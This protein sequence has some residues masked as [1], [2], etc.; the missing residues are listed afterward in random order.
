M[1]H[2]ILN[3]LLAAQILAA[4]VCLGGEREFNGA[5]VSEIVSKD[6]SPEETTAL[7]QALGLRVGRALD[8]DRLDAAIKEA[9]ASGKWV[10]VWVDAE[11]LGRKAKIT[12]RGMKLRTVR[13]LS[14]EGIQEDVLEQVRR[15]I[16]T[17]Q[18]QTADVE[19]FAH[20]RQ[21]LKE[22]YEDRGY[23][24]AQVQFAVK[25]I[26]EDEADVEIRVLPGEPTH[27]SRIQFRGVP[28]SEQSTL[29]DLISLQRG[30]TFSAITLNEGVEK[31]NAYFRANQYPTSRVQDTNLNFIN[32]TKDVEI[33]I[34][35]RMGERFQIRFVGNDV[36][37]DVQL[38]ALLTE[39]VLAQT[40]PTLRITQLIEEKYRTVGYPDCTVA[41]RR[42]LVENGKLNLMEMVVEEGPRTVI[43]DVRFST[44]DRISGVDLDS[45][46]Y[47]VAVGVLQRRL[48]WADGVA[49]T[50][51]AMQNRL[52]TMGYLNAR[53]SDPKT[54]FSEDRRSVILFIDADVGFQTFLAGVDFEGVRSF[55]PEE[56]ASQFS[57]RV[58]KPL[59]REQVPETAN[60]ILKYY[61]DNGFPDARLTQPLD[62]AVVI[63]T[64]QQSARVKFYIDEGQPYR[65]GNVRVEGLRKTKSKVVLRE[66]E[67]VSGDTYSARKIRSSEEKVSLLGLFSKVEIVEV[68]VPGQTGT[69]DL[70]ILVVETK[71]GV[72][73]MGIGT[74]Y[75]EPR[76][77]IRPFMGVTY[78][79]VSGLNQ[80]ASV[81]ADLGVPISRVA[82][83]LTVP[84]LEYSTILAYRYPYA[85]GLPVTFASQLGLDRVEVQPTT[86]T[87]LT[88]ARFEGRLEKKFSPKLTGI[89]RLLRVERT[90][91]Q[92]GDDASTK[93][94]ESIGSMGPGIILDLRDDIFNPRWGSFH[95][96]DI[97]LATSWL[98][99]QQDISFIMAL[100]RNS[101]YFPLSRDIQ[102]AVYA[103]FGLAH[104]FFGDPIAR[105]RLVNELSLGGQ[106]S[107]RGI[108]P[109]ALSPGES[110]REMAYYNGRLE[111]TY[112]LIEDFGVAAFIDTGQI[113]PDFRASQRSDGVGIGLRY[114]TP[115]GPVVVD[116]AK[117]I[118]HLGGEFRFYFTVG[119]I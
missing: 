105:A 78:R 47:E 55:S 54:T 46:F 39:D 92:D 22:G 34:N 96:L 7:V 29:A 37:S 93:K 81:R 43:E 15:K 38:R 48:Y 76:L 73:E 65:I 31:V 11:Q 90:T 14:F 26:D 13:K 66:M 32:G 89:Y 9:G 16:R 60:K 17:D 107:I 117:G 10:R 97:E 80:T 5:V 103:G 44:G 85:L 3:L 6:L 100:W 67:L 84:F 112:T 25:N 68:R 18:E 110:S 30:D 19:S 114:K 27:I 119:T 12:V 56:L 64:D 88:R 42:S 61:A 87:L 21:A 95:S 50:L 86:Q 62:H 45:L 2:L 52:L 51:T 40:D 8:L 72:G 1:K 99:S 102:V 101:F 113:F 53:V 109:R 83:N 77:R 24:S 116:F 115:V 28:E 20:L 104:S 98:F 69:V 58:G 70:R 71:P 91:T 82:G 33:L 108:I 49:E 63:S 75:E 74:L 41:V 59:N 4:G 118:N 111:V 106:G 35:V 23:F 79:N 57:F 94:T 36:F